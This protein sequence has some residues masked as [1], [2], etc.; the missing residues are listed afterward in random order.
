MIGAAVF[1]F[2]YVHSFWTGVLAICKAI[3][4]PAMV[5]YKALEFLYR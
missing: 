2:H 3:V 4:W 5:T 1:Y